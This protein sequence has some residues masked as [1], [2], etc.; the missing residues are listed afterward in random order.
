MGIITLI[1][2]EDYYK[3]NLEG[4]LADLSNDLVEGWKSSFEVATRW[5]RKNLPHITQDVIDHAEALITSC[6]QVEED[7]QNQQQFPT[8]TS[9]SPRGEP[10]DS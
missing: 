8:L 5:A 1:I 3:N 10:I 2:L 9:I 7:P 6:V 4:I